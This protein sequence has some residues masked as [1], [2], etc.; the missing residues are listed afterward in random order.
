MPRGNGLHG[1]GPSRD[2]WNLAKPE[3]LPGAMGKLGVLLAHRD[4]KADGAG[5]YSPEAP[6]LLLEGV[7][8][9]AVGEMAQSAGVQKALPDRRVGLGKPA[10]TQRGGD[11]GVQGVA[12]LFLLDCPMLDYH[13]VWIS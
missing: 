2:H 4:E 11:R 7:D 13:A 8:H 10:C 6:V 9:L 3:A 1:T 5:D 12:S